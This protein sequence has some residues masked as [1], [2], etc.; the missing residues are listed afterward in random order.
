MIRAKRAGSWFRLSKQLRGMYELT[1]K[2]DVQLQ[3]H[4][5]LKALMAVLKT[6]KQDF[7]LAGGAFFRAMKVAWA[8]SEAAFRAGNA[9]ARKWR[10]ETKYIRFLALGLGP[11]QGRP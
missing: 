7:D 6:L 3:S 5:L 4:D 9:E 8:F 10:N 2:L 1:M 11:Q